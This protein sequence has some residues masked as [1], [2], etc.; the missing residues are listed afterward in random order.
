MIDSV[1]VTDGCVG[2]RCHR[3]RPRMPNLFRRVE[4]CHHHA[5]LSYILPRMHWSVIFGHL[6]LYLTPSQVDVIRRALPDENET[7]SPPC[8]FI[9]SAIHRNLALI[10]LQVLSVALQSARLS[11]LPCRRSNPPMRRSN[12]RSRP[13]VMWVRLRRRRAKG[14]QLDLRVRA[15]TFLDLVY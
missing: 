5:M 6:R 15:F 3:R 10:G 7:I 11:F 1:S 4:Q 8:T 14:E 12:Y 9:L 2:S 13:K